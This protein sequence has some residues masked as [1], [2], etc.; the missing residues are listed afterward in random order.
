MYCEYSTGSGIDRKNQRMREVGRV[1]DWVLI[2]FRWLIAMPDS[3]AG[4]ATRR[5]RAGGSPRAWGR[6]R[7]VSLARAVIV[8]K[9]P[10]SPPH[11]LDDVLSWTRMAQCAAGAF[12]GLGRRVFAS[13]GSGGP[14]RDVR[15]GAPWRAGIHPDGHFLYLLRVFA[16]LKARGPCAGGHPTGFVDAPPISAALDRSWPARRECEVYYRVIYG[17]SHAV[18]V[19]AVV[20]FAMAFVLIKIF[21]HLRREG[22][23]A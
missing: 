14:S 2:L 12:A 5:D 13:P 1:A 8:R 19:T 17:A 18:I 11:R 20:T 3:A 15:R 6:L 16:G 21:D 22:R 7:R 9:G 23:P 10:L 4:P